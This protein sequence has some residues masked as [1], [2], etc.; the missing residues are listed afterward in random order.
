MSFTK[1]QPISSQ[2]SSTLLSKQHE[3]AAFSLLEAKRFYGE[4]LLSFIKER[5]RYFKN[6]YEE[7]LQKFK[8]CKEKEFAKRTENILQE[9][10]E[11]MNLKLECEMTLTMQYFRQE[12]WIRIQVGITL[13][14]EF[15]FD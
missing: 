10:K 2:N 5:R 8:N 7:I 13:L 14:T 11:N 9:R 4:L 15:T 3:I 12:L 6:F 1:S